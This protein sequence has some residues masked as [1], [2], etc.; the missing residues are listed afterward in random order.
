MRGS[1]GYD[2][3]LWSYELRALSGHNGKLLWRQRLPVQ[4]ENYY[5]EHAI[6]AP[7]IAD[8]NGDD[9]QEVAVI[10][11]NQ[12]FQ[13][14]TYDSLLEIHALD[15]RTGAPMW[16]CARK[17]PYYGSSQEDP[18]IFP[19][20]LD[21][22]ARQ[23]VC[24][25]IGRGFIFVADSKGQARPGFENRLIAT[26]QIGDAGER[27]LLSLQ[28]G[29]LRA[30]RDGEKTVLWEQPDVTRIRAILPPTSGQPAS[31]VAGTSKGL[32][33]LDA[34][35][36]QPL[37][38]TP[39]DGEEIILPDASARQRPRLITLATDQHQATACRFPLP[40]SPSVVHLAE[41]T[42]RPDPRVIRNL[43]WVRALTRASQSRDNLN[44]A[45]AADLA[46]PLII[47]TV[48]I[49]VLL[50]Q[51]GILAWRR[52]WKPLAI[53]GIALG[54]VCIILGA[55]ALYFDSRGM[56]PIERY[57]WSN[58]YWIALFGLPV[59]G[60]LMVIWQLL[61]LLLASVARRSQAHGF[62]PRAV[63]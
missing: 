28:D 47:L 48:F 7:L 58:W 43:P 54:T 42:S 52:Q 38:R 56:N 11:S 55:I 25:D 15:A 4:L 49:A 35:T 8:L 10:V 37:W 29:K 13:G 17:T 9:K 62:E 24:G 16:K 51:V 61:R 36:G 20:A 5:V 32:I 14:Q 39:N 60:L 12:R 57:S 34:I 33:A 19:V 45:P 27:G 31:V 26:F 63:A 6:S 21:G 2:L 23:S 30:T 1:A 50:I 59:T 3:R 22:D 46:V 18:R 44:D 53:W 40:A 41:V